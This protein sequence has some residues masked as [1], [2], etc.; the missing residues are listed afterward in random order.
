LARSGQPGIPI[1]NLIN[2]LPRRYYDV[3]GNRMVEPLDALLVINHIARQNAT[4]E[5]ESDLAIAGVGTINATPPLQ[6][7]RQGLNRVVQ[8]DFTAQNL[9]ED[10]P[11]NDTPNELWIDDA[12]DGLADLIGLL[13]K[14]QDEKTDSAPIEDIDRA[15]GGLDL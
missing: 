6:A 14:D 13:A 9:V 2:E 12:D 15:F 11:T 10:A 5:G 3:D 8:L 4:G 1:E 7:S